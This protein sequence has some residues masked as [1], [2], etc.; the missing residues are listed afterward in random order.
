MAGR[1]GIIS[2]TLT[3]VLDDRDVAHPRRVHFRPLPGVRP[4]ARRAKLAGW[5]FP[6]GML[7]VRRPFAAVATLVLVGWTLYW[8][9]IAQTTRTLWPVLVAAVL[10]VVASYAVCR[11]L[12]VLQM[13]LNRSVGLCPT[14]DHDLA[15]RPPEDDGCTLCPECGSAWRMRD[16]AP[17]APAREA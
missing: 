9:I 5:R 7:L 12:F 17:A 15:S 8:L 2:P 6:A 11:S 13:A 14:C 10:F 3:S 4:E 1:K 16:D